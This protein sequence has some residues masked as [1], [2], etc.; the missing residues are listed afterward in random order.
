MQSRARTSA[1]E[2]WPS[3]SVSARPTTSLRRSRSQCLRA[4][5]RPVADRAYRG[6]AVSARTSSRARRRGRG[7]RDPAARCARHEGRVLP[8]DVAQARERGDGDRQVPGDARGGRHGRCRHRWRVGRRE[9]EPDAPAVPRRRAV[10]GREARPR[11]RSARGGVADGDDRRRSRAR[12][13]DEI[14]SLEAGKTRRFVLFDLDHFEWT[15]YDDPLQALVWSAISASIAETW[16]NGRALYRDGRV[17]TVD[18]P[19]L[20]KEARERG[21]DIVR[22]AGLDRAATPVTTTLYD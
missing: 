3:G 18:E 17:V 15:P 9:H 8:V 13:E 5:I 7:R 6:S 4:A 21:A 22:R 16:V 20:R 12:W 2:R 11:R 14:G 1:P 10:Q 19:A